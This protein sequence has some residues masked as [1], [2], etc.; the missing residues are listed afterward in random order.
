MYVIQRWKRWKPTILA[1][2]EVIDGHIIFDK[3][4]GDKQ[5]REGL[6]TRGVAVIGDDGN[7]KCYI[8]PSEGEAFHDAC[9]LVFA[10]K[11]VTISDEESLKK[12]A[13]F[14]H[15]KPSN[16]TAPPALTG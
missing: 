5:F 3:S 15:G 14:M 1:A 8:H 6:E 2:Y 16:S 12:L 4:R 13:S 9:L 7:V 11:E 10:T